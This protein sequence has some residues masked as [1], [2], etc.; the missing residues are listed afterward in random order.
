M[1]D[2]GYSIFQPDDPF[3][4]GTGPFRYRREADGTMVFVLTVEPRHCNKDGAAHGGVLMTMADLVAC[5][6]ARDGTDDPAAIT[7]SLNADFVG[8]AEAGE[9]IECRGRV[10]RRT[11][12]MSFASAIVSGADGRVLLN[13]N[14]VIK[15]VR[16]GG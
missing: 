2:P 1:S 3:E 13:G 10:L 7:V 11:G 14:A 8:A 12:G 16:A 4:V 15:R 6:V 5:A 9:T